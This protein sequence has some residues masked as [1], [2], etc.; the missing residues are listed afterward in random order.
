M[1]AQWLVAV[2]KFEQ[3]VLFR[4]SRTAQLLVSAGVLVAL[5]VGVITLGVS[6]LPV[7]REPAPP[8]PLASSQPV[9]VTGADV[10][11]L[12]QARIPQAVLAGPVPSL[13]AQS[14]PTASTVAPTAQNAAALATLVDSLRKAL[15]GRGVSWAQQAGPLVINLLGRYDSGGRSIESRAASGETYL[16]NP[17]GFEDKQTILHE[18]LPIVQSS[19]QG[20]ELAYMTAWR[21]LREEREQAR[22]GALLAAEGEHAQR[23]M[24]IEAQYQ[25]KRLARATTRAR[26]LIY[27]PWTIGALV[28]AGL[29]LSLLGI[30]RNT[31]MMER[32]LTSLQDNKK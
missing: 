13:P 25:A 2:D 23:L 12:L 5:L 20:Q 31:R 18:L 11:A 26:A 9:Q 21:S 32:L 3:G 30:E 14:P 29:A 10:A 24:L 27:L 16:I 19:P 4:F 8:Q 7:S 17:S 15:T 1:K 22:R 28:V 6:Y